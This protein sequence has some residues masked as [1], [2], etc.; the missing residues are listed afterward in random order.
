M[1]SN[2]SIWVRLIRHGRIMKQVTIPAVFENPF[3]ALEKAMEKLDVSNPLWSS[4]NQSEWDVFFQTR[5]YP[6]DFME[7]VS[8]DRMEIEYIN[9]SAPKRKSADPRNALG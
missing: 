5:F 6:E 8:F 9:P 7:S 2:T 1:S 3:P 4:K